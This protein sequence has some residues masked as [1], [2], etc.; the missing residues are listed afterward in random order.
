MYKADILMNSC[1]EITATRILCHDKSTTSWVFKKDA[2]LNLR[3]DIK[4]YKQ[5]ESIFPITFDYFYR[6]Q[7]VLVKSETIRN[8]A[9]CAIS[10][11]IITAPYLVHPAIILL[12]FFGFIALAFE[13][14]AL[15]A[16]WDV[17]LNSI[18][19]ITSIMSI[20]FAVD[21]SA[22]IAHAYLISNLETPEERIIQ[23]LEEIG[24]SVLMGGE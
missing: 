13:L 21:Y 4:S 6:E 10:V 20:G 2:M 1:G 9:L 12:V 23:A 16:I 18:S 3:E 15:M 11:L 8:L 17:A 7:I 22:H 14:F 5:I 19:M 24:A